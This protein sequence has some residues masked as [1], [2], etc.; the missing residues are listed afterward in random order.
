MIT[1]RFHV[2]DLH[3]ALQLLY[4][5]FATLAGSE[6]TREIQR[7]LKIHP[8]GVWGPRTTA[9]VAVFNA[10]L[11][12]KEKQREAFETLD[13]M[14]R[15]YFMYLGK[16]PRYKKHLQNWLHRSDDVKAWTM[17]YLQ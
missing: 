12:T 6:A 7:L 2:W 15:D 1:N 10:S 3:P 4:A 16:H 8:D 17:Q 5:D 14:K 9:A 13:R 11:T